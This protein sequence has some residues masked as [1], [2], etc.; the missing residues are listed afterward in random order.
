MKKVCFK[1]YD[2]QTHLREIEDGAI[3]HTKAELI[4]DET[5]QGEI[6]KPILE[7]AESEIKAQHEAEQKKKEKE[8]E[9]HSERI[10]LLKGFKPE[11]ADLAA[12]RSAIK[13]LI[14]LFGVQ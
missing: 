6:P 14:E 12:C 5:K 11:N 9:D 4:W 2:G 3:F 7:K 1:T 10:R 8:M 13:T